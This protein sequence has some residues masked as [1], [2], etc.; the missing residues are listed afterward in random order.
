MATKSLE[1]TPKERE[2]LVLSLTAHEAQV[3]RSME[4]RLNHIA[5]EKK[6]T[7]VEQLLSGMFNDW[8]SLI[9]IRTLKER[10]QRVIDLSDS[11]MPKK[12]L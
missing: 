6:A 7:H 10:I 5:N 12:S 3:L 1:L 8:Q 4:E 9:E 11:S 2:T